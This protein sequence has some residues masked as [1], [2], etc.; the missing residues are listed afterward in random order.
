MVR[1]VGVEL[2]TSKNLAGMAADALMHFTQSFHR[3][4]VLRTCVTS[5]MARR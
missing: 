4:T 3:A 2:S 5:V 1:M